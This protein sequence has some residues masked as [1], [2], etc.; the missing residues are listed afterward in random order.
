MTNRVSGDPGPPYVGGGGHREGLGERVVG[1][2]GVPQ[3]HVERGA[4]L[5]SQPQ[6]VEVLAHGQVADGVGQAEGVGTGSGREV[7]QVS[8][9]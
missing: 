2:V 3:R 6:G 8:R 9:R 1:G 4:G 5:G 7:Q